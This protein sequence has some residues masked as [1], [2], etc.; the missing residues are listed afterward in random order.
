M[1]EE[2]EKWYM[3]QEV[4]DFINVGWLEKVNQEMNVRHVYYFMQNGYFRVVGEKYVSGCVNYTTK[5]NIRE[6]FDQDGWEML[7]LEAMR[8]YRKKSKSE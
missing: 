4:V 5:G 6:F 3:A 1:N 2:E 8:E 7:W